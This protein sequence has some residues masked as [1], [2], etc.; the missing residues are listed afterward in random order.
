MSIINYLPLNEF[1]RLLSQSHA[2][3]F[4]SRYESFALLPLDALSAGSLVVS[5]NVRG[6]VRDYLLK[7]SRLGRY[8]VKFGDVNGLVNKIAE[9]INLWY[10]SEDE[11]FS[12]AK[13]ARS[14]AERFSID[15]IARV[16]IELLTKVL[17]A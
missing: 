2:L 6:F 1:A 5:F 17:N 11:Y 8:V 3:L 9:L 4:T 10:G 13:Y 12:L 15:N 14:F 16:Y 7:D